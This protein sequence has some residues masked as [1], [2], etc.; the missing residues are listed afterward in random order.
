MPKLKP[1][2]ISPSDAEDAAIDAGIASD[3]DTYELGPQEFACLKRKGRPPK[4]RPIITVTV[5]K[6][7]DVI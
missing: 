3:P 6:D 7:T 1:G 2:H 4:A 5:P